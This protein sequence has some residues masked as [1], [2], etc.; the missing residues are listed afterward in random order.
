M[1]V[2]L[3]SGCVTVAFYT[4]LCVVAR[5]LYLDAYSKG[6]LGEFYTFWGVMH[7]ISWAAQFVGHGLFEKRAPVIHKNPLVI[8]IAPHFVV[9]EILFFFGW[10]P[11]LFERCDKR[12]KAN[13]KEHN[14]MKA[15][16]G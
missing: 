3:V 6:T 13:I 5:N 2:D 15:K 12:I 11:D 8:F 1:D 14:E 16:A 7:V 9:V 4:F 10:R